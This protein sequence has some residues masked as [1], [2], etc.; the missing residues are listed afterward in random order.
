M[1]PAVSAAW[2]AFNAPLEGVIH[3]MYLDVLGLVTTGMGNLIDPVELALPLPW[4]R[5]GAAVDQEAI[6]AEWTAIKQNAGLAQAGATAAGRVATLRLDDGAID[7]LIEAKLADNE[8]TL[9]GTAAFADF[10]EW[11]ADAQLGLLSMAWAMGPSFAPGYPRFCAA[12]Q[13]RDFAA[14]AGECA[15]NDA[16]NPGLTRRN[17]ANK[18]AFQLAATATDPAVLRSP[19]PPG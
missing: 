16:G 3:W 9:T 1:Q 18:L 2:R 10:E 17:A 8:R 5:D 4:T 15:M 19:V 7:Q 6:R 11:P 13:A 14:A 12:C